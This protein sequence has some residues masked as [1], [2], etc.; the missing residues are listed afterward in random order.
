[1]AVKANPNGKTTTRAAAKHSG[2]GKVKRVDWAFR[3]LRH[4]AVQ[5]L[6]RGDAKLRR[7]LNALLSKPRTF[8]EMERTVVQQLGPRK[9]PTVWRKF[10]DGFFGHQ[11][12]RHVA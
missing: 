5:F 7:D 8:T 4:Q 11:I 3:R 1:M 10:L 2:T 12:N 9:G 6:A